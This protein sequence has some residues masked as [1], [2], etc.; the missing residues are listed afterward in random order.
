MSSLVPL[1]AADLGIMELTDSSDSDDELPDFE[2]LLQQTSS[3]KSS[4]S[5]SQRTVKRL[6]SMKLEDD[7]FEMVGGNTPLPG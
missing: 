5:S 4:S 2:D 7:G 1:S 3:Q 6:E